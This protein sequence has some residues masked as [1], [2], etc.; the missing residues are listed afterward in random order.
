MSHILQKIAPIGESRDKEL[1]K[2]ASSY[3]YV[4]HNGADL[5]AH[6]YFPKDPSPALKPAIVFFH[7][8]FWD[9]PMP[10][11]FVPH[12]NHFA[13]RGMVSICFEYRV[14][15]KH[16]STPLDAIDDSIFAI[17]WLFANGDIL[18]IDMNQ[19]IFSGSA[20][21]AY[22][23]LLL[24]MRKDKDIAPP[25]RP[26]ALVLFSALVNTTPKGQVSERFPDIK[27]S[28]RLSPSKLLRR[29]LPA[30]LFLHGNQDRITPLSE[31]QS[32]CRRMKWRGNRCQLVSFTGA[33]H[34]FF[35]FNVS[36][37][38]FE[39]TI[40]AADRFLVDQGIL[41]EAPEETFEAH[42]V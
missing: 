6:V 38:N 9:N 23:A 13:A 5:L 31:I 30:M 41:P 40:H 1:L 4:S 8:G 22:L 25:F 11:Q 35:N 12:C 16:Q 14:S 17:N 34:S 3:V 36:H 42:E 24:A 33:E 29:K 26:K 28:I 2:S 19:I 18:G 21:G 39:I 37:N 7:G 32:F 20:G 27:S 15:A 10:S